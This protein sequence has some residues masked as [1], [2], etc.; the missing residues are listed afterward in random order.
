MQ[1]FVKK[2]TA[3][4]LT[5]LCI[6][7]L[8]AVCSIVIFSCKPDQLSVAIATVLEVPAPVFSE[9]GG[10]YTQDLVL[11]M[12]NEMEGVTIYYTLDGS[13]PT[14]ESTPYTE[15]IIIAG[16]GTEMTIKAI[17][18]FTDM[19]NSPVISATF[20]VDY[21]PVAEPEFSVESGFYNDD[22]TVSVTCATEGATIYYTDDG[23]PVSENSEVYDPEYPFVITGPD[24]EVIINAFAVRGGMQS[25]DTVSKRY[26]V[27]YTD[28]A[29]PVFSPGGGTYTGYSP[30]TLSCNTDGAEIYYKF[31]EP[32]YD[33]TTL[34][35]LWDAVLYSGSIDIPLADRNQVQ[36]IFAYAIKSGMEPSSLTFATYEY[37]PE[38]SVGLGDPITSEYTD[39]ADTYNFGAVYEDGSGGI[40]SGA[41]TFSI[42]N[43]GAKNLS[44]IS[45]SLSGGSNPF[46][47]GGTPSASLSPGAS[48]TFTVTFDPAVETTF[49]NSVEINSDDPDE[50]LF[51]FAITGKSFGSYI[52]SDLLAA[53]QNDIGYDLA[54]D[55]S[56]DVVIVGYAN[57]G[58]DNDCA[59]LKLDSNYTLDSN[60]GG[61][62][63]IFTLDNHDADV[64]Y[65]IGIDSTGKII[66]TGITGVDGGTTRPGRDMIMIGLDSGGSLDPNFASSGIFRM[67][68]MGG[69]TVSDDGVRDY[70]WD[71]LIAPD[72][73]IY[74][75][76][77][78]S[79]WGTDNYVAKF[80]SSG[81]LDTAW[82]DQ[83]APSPNGV[84]IDG[85]YQEENRRISGTPGSSDVARALLL[86]SGEII[87]ACFSEYDKVPDYDPTL[88]RIT[89]TGQLDTTFNYAS[90]MNTPYENLSGGTDLRDY[91]SPGALAQDSSGNFYLG[92]GGYSDGSTYDGYVIKTDSSGSLDASFAGDG[93]FNMG[94]AGVSDYIQDVVWDAA[95]SR[96]YAVGYIT[97]GSGNYDLYVTSL[98]TSGNID[99]SFGVNGV[100]QHDNAAGGSDNDVGREAVLSGD[101][102]KLF[103][104]GN[105]TNPNGDYDIALWVIEL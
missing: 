85:I 84:D 57:N 56:G 55:G 11:E 95:R 14:T 8:F 13:D 26:T 28:V 38:I 90:D 2:R 104:V 97:N 60:F 50:N 15:P 20:V 64:L 6:T 18:S 66:A 7:L 94:T 42:R 67:D 41:I 88:Q 32:P 91:V 59:V 103:V 82:G 76:G 96:I 45:V 35:P 73:S 16:D 44:G 68:N 34:E 23:T 87:A 93:A 54:L 22:L 61:G 9:E 24:T 1:S 62:D 4:R 102:S 48:T 17:A 86:V 75:A 37:E 81:S 21:E 80:T 89:A 69:F 25:S 31:N 52:F 79:G 53:G 92:C 51:D 46:S 58:T 74:V 47:I 72:D 12:I 78:T 98:D 33:E 63:G 30:I 83:T 27:N 10:T 105:S 71:I 43:D 29:K 39:G 77:Q 101:G 100:Y 36:T 40:N 49:N 99:T 70:G 65:S 19:Q 5:L 3:K